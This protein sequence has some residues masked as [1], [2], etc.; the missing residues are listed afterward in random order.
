MRY[1]DDSMTPRRSPSPAP[2]PPPPERQGQQRREQ[3]RRGPRQFFVYLCCSTA[4]R[5]VEAGLVTAMLPAI[6]AALD[7]SPAAERLVGSAP[8]LGLLPAGL[9]GLCLLHALPARRVVIGA[10]AAIA[11][12]GIWCALAPSIWTLVAAR[13]GGALGFGITAVLCPTWVD[14]HAPASCRTSWLGIYHAMLLVGLAAGFALG[15]VAETLGSPGWNL[16]YGLE[17]VLMAGC[18]A[19]AAS[20]PPEVAQVYPF[21]RLPHLPCPP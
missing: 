5:S 15:G 17:A 2:S 3:E 7:L 19:W 12:L 20:F 1:N 13:M 14:A 16:L 4:L 21:S 18:A 11:A 6:H 10:D 8:D 9:A